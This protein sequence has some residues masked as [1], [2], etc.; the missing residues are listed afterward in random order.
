MRKIT[1]T[2][3][4]MSNKYFAVYRNRTEKKKKKYLYVCNRNDKDFLLNP[5]IETQK[6][7]RIHK[8]FGKIMK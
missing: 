8:I 5:H 3:L 7:R 1:S 4:F 6:G 2:S